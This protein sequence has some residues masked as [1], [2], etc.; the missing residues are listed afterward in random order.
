M[1]VI[2]DNNFIEIM[3]EYNGKKKWIENDKAYLR[4]K[5]AII[6]GA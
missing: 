2:F 6:L 5:H 4:V 1:I 3:F